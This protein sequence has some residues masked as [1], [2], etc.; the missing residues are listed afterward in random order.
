MLDATIAP[1]ASLV[2]AVIPASASAPIPVVKPPAATTLSAMTGAVQTAPAARDADQGDLR[3][4]RGDRQ[5]KI[6]LVTTRARPPGGDEPQKP[7]DVVPA[8]SAPVATPPPLPPQ[9]A[10]NATP[11][12]APQTAPIATPPPPP[13]TA[14]DATP[15]ARVEPK[16]PV[17]PRPTVHTPATKANKAPAPPASELERRLEA[18]E[19]LHHDGVINDAEFNRRRAVLLKDL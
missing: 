10:P 18:L 19:H 12:P 14:P 7:S 1:E 13:Q 8:R 11:P 6:A 4:D 2:P 5:R 17:V 3:R 15:P 16:P 9:T